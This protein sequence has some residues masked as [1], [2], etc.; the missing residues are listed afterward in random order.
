MV[1]TLRTI[2]L[3]FCGFCASGATEKEKK[4]LLPLNWHRQPSALR[5]PSVHRRGPKV[6][7]HRLVLQ[8]D[9]G[10]NRFSLSQVKLQK[11]KT[12]H[13]LDGSER[14]ASRRLLDLFEIF[15]AHRHRN[16]FCEY[17][18]GWRA[19]RQMRRQRARVTIEELRSGL[20]HSERHQDLLFSKRGV[21][22]R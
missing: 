13:S 17:A 3:S 19:R 2:R 5:C 22:E 7:Q 11:K 21:L 20:P 12:K 18:D 8:T 16:Q 14:R 9:A 1:T 4:P 15:T 10:Q 6:Q